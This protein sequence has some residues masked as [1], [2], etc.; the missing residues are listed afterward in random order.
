MLRARIWQSPPGA[1]A[2]AQWPRHLQ[3]YSRILMKTPTA[4][5]GAEDEIL[6]LT[7]AETARRIS[8]RE[9]TSRETVEAHIARIELL[10]EDLNAVVYELFERARSDADEADRAVAAGAPIGP[11]HGVPITIKESFDVEGTPTTVGLAHRAS[12]LATRDGPLVARLRGAGA[13]VLGKTNVPQL[14]LYIEADNPLHGRTN[15]PWDP[16][17]TPGGSSGGEA[18]I[19]AAG[20][21]ALGLGSD[22]GGSIRVPAHFCG[23]HGLKPTSGRLTV[24]GSADEWLFAG[25]EAIHSQPGPLARSAADVA[26]AYR[27]LAAPGL[28]EIDASVAPVPIRDPADVRL[29]EL[30]VGFYEDDGFFPASPALRR[31]VREAAAAL[32]A[33]GLEVV[34]FRPPEIEEAMRLYF[35]IL[36]A[37]GPGKLAELLESE[38]KTDR[39]IGA[40]V[41]LA[42]T[43]RPLA[44]TLARAAAVAGQV[45]LAGTMRSVHR[46]STAEYWDL[47]TRMNL[48][49]TRFLASMDA[50]EL[51]VLLSPPLA[52]P[53]LTHGDSYWL[54]TAGSYSFLYNLLGMPAGVSP[55]TRVQAGEETDRTPSRDMVD[56]AARRVEEDSAGLPVGVQIAARHWR[57]DQVLAVME[58]VGA[59][60]RSA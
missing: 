58:A 30:R 51:D 27:V 54:T 14:L 3:L 52:L 41:K 10:H 43:P 48:Y 20:G 53:A 56:R 12:H 44:R 17:R 36:S 34:P 15:S 55:V 42:G 46:V 50:Q 40:L 6:S 32:K 35:G 13:I 22:I 26:L 7:A 2:E 1:G 24:R 49:R 39:R 37:A 45:R 33:A 31:A 19:I 28:H 59:E 25:Q 23:L 16:D 38:P 8:A 11:L 4:V 57:E 18:A 60:L 29:G 9:M 21:S 47:V 5:V